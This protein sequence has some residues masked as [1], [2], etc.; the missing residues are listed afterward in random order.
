MLI[1]LTPRQ[2]EVLNL[3]LDDYERRIAGDDESDD[4]DPD[5]LSDREL[6]ILTLQASGY[7]RKQIAIKCGITPDTVKIHVYHIYQK[8]HVFNSTH[9]TLIAHKRRIINLDQLEPPL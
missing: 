8:L 6:E 5:K 4:E 7:S 1:D 9:A 3:L 2:A